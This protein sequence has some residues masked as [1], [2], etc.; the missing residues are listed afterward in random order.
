V[1]EELP[2]RVAEGILG[3]WVCRESHAAMSAATGLQK[4]TF[5]EGRSTMLGRCDCTCN[6][7][8]TA[9]ITTA[10]VAMRGTSRSALAGERIRNTTT[11]IAGSETVQ[12]RNQD[13]AGATHSSKNKPIT[14][15]RKARSQA[16]GLLPSPRRR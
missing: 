5:L 8:E 14:L 13:G 10:T 1:E 9:R 11:I 7:S 3:S 2:I 15:T 16:S 6:G 4:A 12:S